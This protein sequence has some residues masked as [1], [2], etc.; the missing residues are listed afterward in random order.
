MPRKDWDTYFMDMA[1]A[2]KGQATCPRKEVGAVVVTRDKRIAGTGFNGAP[3]GMPHCHDEGCLMDDANHCTRVIHAEVNALM[4]ALK[5]NEAHGSTVYVTVYPCARCLNLMIQ[6]G[7]KKVVY[8]EVY[9]NTV[10]EELAKAAS[11]EL[12]NYSIFQE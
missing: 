6:C 1:H 9:R 4:E 10:Q 5:R 12:V 7:V 3:S 11:I 2:V 8:H